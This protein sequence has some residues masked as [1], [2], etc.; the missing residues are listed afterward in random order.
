MSTDEFLWRTRQYLE[1]GQLKIS[2]KTP[3]IKRTHAPG[4][5][6]VH[7]ETSTAINSPV[8]IE[9]AWRVVALFVVPARVAQAFVYV[10]DHT[11]DA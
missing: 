6:I 5:L 3:K 4:S 11:F 9:R 7:L 1:I 10:C 8:A 2:R